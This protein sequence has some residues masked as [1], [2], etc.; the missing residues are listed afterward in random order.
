MHANDATVFPNDHT[1]PAR[2]RRILQ[3]MANAREIVQDL[4][5][6][7]PL[8]YWTDLLVTASIA[9][10]SFAAAV[11]A[12]GVVRGMAFTVAVF[13][14]YRAL[15]FTHELAHLKPGALP[16]FRGVWHLLC[17]VPLL[18]PQFLYGAVH[19]PHHA[20]EAYATERDAE[21]DALAGAP[22]KTVTLFALC[23][24]QPILSIVRFAVL[25]PASLLSARVRRVVRV[26]ASSMSLRID[27]A[28]D[29]P[30][31]EDEKRAWNVQETITSAFTWSILISVMTGFL[32][33]R[34]LASWALLTICI[35]WVNVLRVIG[36]THRYQ[37]EEKGSFAGQ[38]ED[39]VN[40]ASHSLSALLI[41]PVGLRFHALH[42][43]LPT[44]PYHALPIAHRRLIQGLPS[45]SL[46]HRLSVP[47]VW[48]GFMNVCGAREPVAHPETLS[49]PS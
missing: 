10:L 18:A 28:R 22:G 45:D 7:R 26:H 35:S 19:T 40:V 34:V 6:P 33:W 2:E 41:C 31:R 48:R 8:V 25:A 17:S 44:L 23:V 47:S 4:F 9:W 30:T 49:R 43:L 13:A 20:R 11:V 12:D 46:Y 3:T 42:H 16:G 1:R 29:L 32:P 36:A 15:A 37:H 5:A 27:Y 24:L 14:F 21:Y 39:S 38:I